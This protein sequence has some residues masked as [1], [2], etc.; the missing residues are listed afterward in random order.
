MQNTK[1]I[2]SNNVVDEITF[3]SQEE[4]VQNIPHQGYKIDYEKLRTLN[5]IFQDEIISDYL[6]LTKQVE[7]NFLTHTSSTNFLKRNFKVQKKH[8]MGEIFNI[9]QHECFK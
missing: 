1:F 5:P 7:K 3:Y 4:K 8:N 6:Y 2:N 9:L